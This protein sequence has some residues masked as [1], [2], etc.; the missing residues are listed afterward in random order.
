MKKRISQLAGIILLFFISSCSK[1]DGSGPVVRE[2]VPVSSFSKLALELNATV[3]YSPSADFKLEIEGEKNI[4]N[5]LKKDVR[6]QTLFIGVRD[7]VTIRPR[8]DIK[9]YI[10]APDLEQLQISGIGNIVVMKPYRPEHLYLGISGSGSISIPLLE[11]DRLIADI[12]GSGTIV[13]DNGVA[14]NADVDIRG[15]GLA[16]WENLTVDSVDSRISG[17]GTLR[18]FVNNFIKTKISGSGTFF[19]KGNPIIE[20]DISGTGRIV[21]L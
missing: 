21:R 12:S 13:V 16:D 4:L 19:Y 7:N 2:T 11:T 20:S 10:N 6:H 3:F 15:S 9:I 8:H 14:L 5:A 18:M 17:S 1:V